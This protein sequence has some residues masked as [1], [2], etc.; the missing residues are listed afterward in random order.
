MGELWFQVLLRSTKDLPRLAADY[1]AKLAKNVL[2]SETQS[3]QMNPDD[4]NARLRLG[5]ALS[6]Q[7]RAAEARQQFE[8]A[9]R[10]KPDFDQPHY[11]L[12]VM[13]RQAGRLAEA[14]NEFETALRL[15]P[16]NSDAHGNLGLICAGEGDA[17]GAESHFR[18]ALRINPDD[19]RAR[20]CLQELLQIEANSRKPNQGSASP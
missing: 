19:S 17:A 10:L 14:R 3:V 2:A 9:L 4:P 6:G 13:L 11:F 5:I 7:G 16:D 15:N 20:A 18:E 1:E 8:T 12:G